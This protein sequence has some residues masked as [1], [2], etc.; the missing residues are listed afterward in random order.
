MEHSAIRGKNEAVLIICK[1]EVA[2][3]S[4]TIYKLTEGGTLTL[5][6]DTYTI[7]DIGNSYYTSSITTPNEDCFLCVNFGGYPTFIRVGDPTIRFLY[8]RVNA[9]ST[10]PYSQFG[11]NGAVLSSGSLTDLNNGFYMF[12]PSNL[13][14]SIIEVDTEPSVL[15]VPYLVYSSVPTG[16]SANANFIDVGYNTIA[17]LGEEFS[18][19]DTDQ[20]KWVLNNLKHAKASDLAKAVTA[21]Y[22]L[23][24]ASDEADPLWIGNYI[25]YIRAWD[26][27]TLGG[28][29]FMYFPSRTPETNVHN[30]NLVT[31]DELDNIQVRGLTILLKQK[32]T[33]TPG[34]G[35][36]IDF[37]SA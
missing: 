9:G 36:V 6:T 13:G 37:R 5:L 8:Y 11:V 34:D 4:L 35:V 17:F 32:L 21:K 2:P 33:S 30:F 29:A 23:T 15:K 22:N 26:E 18:Y 24:W 28:R 1:T 27:E 16:Y 20:G 7:N 12:T 3:P 14:L 25:S 19:F 10:I 31:R